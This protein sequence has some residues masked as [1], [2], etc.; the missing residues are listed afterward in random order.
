MQRGRRE[1][2][3]RRRRERANIIRCKWVKDLK[4]IQIKSGS[5]CSHTSEEEENGA[6]LSFVGQ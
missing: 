2:R 6:I 4:R 5:L 1:G 3:M